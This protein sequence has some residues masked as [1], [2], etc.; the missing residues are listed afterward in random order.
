MLARIRSALIVRHQCI[1]ILPQ[2]KRGALASELPENLIPSIPDPLHARPRAI[3]LHALTSPSIYLS[4]ATLRT[5]LARV[6]KNVRCRVICGLD[7]VSRRTR[8]WSSLL[9]FLCPRPSRAGSLQSP[10]FSYGRFDV[11][12]N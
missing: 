6:K 1:G 2:V 10:K 9:S 3:W 7:D 5:K 4:S 8:R 11:I 12:R